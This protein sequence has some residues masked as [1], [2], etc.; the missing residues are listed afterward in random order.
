MQITIKHIPTQNTWTMPVKNIEYGIKNMSDIFNR[1]TATGI[2]F[3]SKETCNYV[4][5]SSAIAKECVFYLVSESE[6]EM[7]HMKEYFE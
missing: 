5:I 2:S 3:Y 4:H 1:D 6:E 7:Q